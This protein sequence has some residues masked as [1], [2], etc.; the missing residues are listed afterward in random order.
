MAV[1]VTHTDLRM[2]RSSCE[3]MVSIT[4][5]QLSA[6]RQQRRQRRQLQRDYLFITFLYQHEIRVLK[7]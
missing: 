6:L 2:D 4:N 1:K 5:C 7:R 3:V